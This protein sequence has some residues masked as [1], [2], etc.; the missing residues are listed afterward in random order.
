MEYTGIAYDSRKVRPGDVFVA[1]PGLKV[2]GTDF[3]PE[4]IEKGAKTI[5]A[6]KKV[7]VPSSV[8]FQKV[9][10]ARKALAHLANK[11]YDYPSQKVKLI[12]VTGTNGKTTTVYLIES[13]LKEAGHKAGVIGTIGSTLTTPES[14]ELQAI[15]A[16]NRDEEKEHAAMLLEWIRRRDPAMD[17]ELKDYLFTDKPIAHG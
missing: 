10:S 17:K 11:F 6:E 12:G 4:A 1:I 14:L 8:D 15:L 13:I 5:V 7:D 9:P 2:D 16:H 3:I